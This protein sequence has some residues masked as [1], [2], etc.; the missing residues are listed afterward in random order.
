MLEN[1]KIFQQ[2]STSFKEIWQEYLDIEAVVLFS[3]LVRRVQLGQQL[4]RVSA[5]ALGQRFGK[6]LQGSSKF[7]RGVLL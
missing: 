6:Y 1:A 2:T 7:A 5:G 4:G 3:F